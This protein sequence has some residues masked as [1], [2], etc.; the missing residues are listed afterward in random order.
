[1]PQKSSTIKDMATHLHKDFIKKF[2]FARVWG[3]SSKFPG[4]SVGL[5]HKL[6][7]DDIVEIHLD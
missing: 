5:N 4:Q 1:M 3:S 7:D 2:R 6:E